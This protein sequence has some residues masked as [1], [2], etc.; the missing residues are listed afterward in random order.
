MVD[1]GYTSISVRNT[2]LHIEYPED[3]LELETGCQRRQRSWSAPGLSMADDS[4]VAQRSEQEENVKS[5]T[6]ERLVKISLQDDLRDTEYASSDSQAAR[7]IDSSDEA[8]WQ[9]K[10]LLSSIGSINHPHNCVECQF[11]FFKL[12]G[13]SSGA[14]CR[15]CHEVHPRKSRK[16]NRKILV[17]AETTRSSAKQ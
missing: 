4:V 16:K 11:H 14:D 13:C 1:F 8:H 12:S 2:F 5:P 7:S 10:E 17:R 3:A 6:A 9:E 15:F